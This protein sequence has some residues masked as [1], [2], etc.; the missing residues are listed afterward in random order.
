MYHFV[1]LGLV[2]AG[3]LLAAGCGLPRRQLPPPPPHLEW[4][5]RAGV[6]PGRPETQSPQ[7]QAMGDFPT[8]EVALNDG[9]YEVALRAFRDAVEKDPSSPLLQLRLAM[10][11]VR[12]GSLE[13]ALQHCQSVVA[14]RPHNTEG[15]LLLAGILS[16]L[17]RHDAAAV[18]T[19][20]PARRLKIRKP[21]SRRAVRQAGQ[22]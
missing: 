13:E 11:L 15:R 9:N 14:M 6:L 22:I 1:R 8:G 2:I 7:V 17:T 4:D 5:P 16:A 18:S 10:L 3:L 12:K 19:A 20:R 21:I